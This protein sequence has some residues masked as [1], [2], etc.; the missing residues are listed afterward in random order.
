MILDVSMSVAGQ[1]DTQTTRL[2]LSAF[3]LFSL[4]T[5]CMQGGNYNMKPN[6]LYAKLVIKVQD[7]FVISC[8]GTVLVCV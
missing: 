4:C 5:R 8:V 2:P 3:I 7:V 6:L 1:T